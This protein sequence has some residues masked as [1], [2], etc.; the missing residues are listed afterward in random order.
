MNIGYSRE[1]A[2]VEDALYDQHTGSVAIME[3]CP[4]TALGIGNRLVESCGYRQNRIFPV[5]SLAELSNAL[6]RH[7]PRL[8][9]MEL[10]GKSESVLDGLRLISEVQ[11]NLP[12]TAIVVCT[13]MDEPRVLRQLIASGIR[14][15]MLKQEPAIALAHC[16]QQVLAGKCSFSHRIRQRQ[17][18]QN[19]AGRPLTLRELDVLSQLFSGKSVSG[20]AVTMCRDIRTVSTHKRNAMLKLGFHN[21]GEL[22]LQGKWMA[23]NGPSFVR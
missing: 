13:A 10:C 20:V 14:G 5:A 6:A 12:N 19:A 16:V 22:Y 2:L 15:L 7:Q 1:A 9:I 8:L 18:H 17:L 11:E 4:I 21:D 23:A 3:P